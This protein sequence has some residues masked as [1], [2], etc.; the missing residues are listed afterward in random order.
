MEVKLEVT[1]FFRCL[2]QRVPRFAGS[3]ALQGVEVADVISSELPLN[4]QVDTI[5]HFDQALQ[6]VPPELAASIRKGQRDIADK[7]RQAEAAL[8]D[9]RVG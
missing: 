2:G 5:A 7:A 8:A 3:K 4:P 6:D 1:K 9:F